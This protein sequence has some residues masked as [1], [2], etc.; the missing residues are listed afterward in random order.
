MAGK[1]AAQILKGEAK[2]SDIPYET[3]TEYSTYINSDAASAMEI[4]VPSDLAAKAI[5]CK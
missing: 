2:A 4:T 5:E 3:V 1:L